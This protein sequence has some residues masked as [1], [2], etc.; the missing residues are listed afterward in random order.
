M[1]EN[2]QVIEVNNG[3]ELVAALKNIT[4]TILSESYETLKQGVLPKKE[5]FATIEEY[6][7][8]YN[9][10][11]LELINEIESIKKSVFT[12]VLDIYNNFLSEKAETERLYKLQKE[13]SY[14]LIEYTSHH[15]KRLCIFTVGESLILPAYTPLFIIINSSRVV[16]DYAVKKKNERILEISDVLIKEYKNLQYPL[17]EFLDTLRSDYHKSKR[18]L[19]EIK[20]KSLEGKEIEKDLLPIINPKRI[21]LPIIESESIPTEHQ[22]DK[23]IQFINKNKK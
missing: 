22:E 11:S 17:Y 6:K 15:M 9:E 8:A 3:E 5:D 23:P 21:N 20:T 13:E 10:A 18:E 14:K 16:L 19:E 2:M 1:E 4:S 12:S 7:L